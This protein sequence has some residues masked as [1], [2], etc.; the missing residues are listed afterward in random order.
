MTKLVFL[1]YLYLIYPYHTS[2]LF[3]TQVCLQRTELVLSLIWTCNG[4]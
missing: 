4:M 2:Q 1:K 3:L